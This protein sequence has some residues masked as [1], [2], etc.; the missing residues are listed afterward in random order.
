MLF[1]PTI[2]PPF[3]PEADSG[4]YPPGA[5]RGFDSPE[6]FSLSVAQHLPRLLRAARNILDGDDLAW[7]AVQ[8]TLL[9]IWVG[10]WLPADPEGALLHLVVKSSLHNSRCL[11]RR[12]F[13]ESL[14][15]QW[16]KPC[17]DEDPLSVVESLERAEAVRDAVKGIAEEYR[18]VIELF[19]F[20][21]LSYESIARLLNLPVGTVRSRLYRARALLRRRL[22][23]RFAAA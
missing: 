4:A 11:R 6:H 16:S 20:D 5:P 7:D 18:S 1:S 13:H 15:V 14:A 8:E 3:T 10:G 17:C 12:R 19:E 21:G 9:R 23:S 22:R 2:V